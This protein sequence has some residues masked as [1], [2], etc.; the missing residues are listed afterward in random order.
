MT[1]YAVL[2]ELQEAPLGGIVTILNPNEGSDFNVIGPY[3]YLFFKS[4]TFDRQKY[5]YW[6]DFFLKRQNMYPIPSA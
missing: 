2:L 5:R 3:G 6:M 4:S 1:S